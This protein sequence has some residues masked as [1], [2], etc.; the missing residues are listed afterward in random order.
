VGKEAREV[1]KQDYIDEL[2]E[3][4]DELL[5]NLE[6]PFMRGQY[7]ALEYAKDLARNIRPYCLGRSNHKVNV[8]LTWEQARRVQELLTK[9]ELDKTIY[10]KIER[11]MANIES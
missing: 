7:I 8:S 3:G 11:G 10:T 6:D 9:G 5:G 4:L 2:Q 1:T